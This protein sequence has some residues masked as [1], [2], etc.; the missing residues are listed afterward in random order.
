MQFNTW[1]SCD[2]SHTP[3]PVVGSSRISE[4]H[5]CLEDVQTDEEKLQDTLLSSESTF[6]PVQSDLE[7]PTLQSDSEDETETFEPDSL[8]PKRP[9]QTKNHT[10]GKKHCSPLMEKQERNVVEDDATSGAAGIV[11]SPGPRDSMQQ[12][13]LEKST[14]FYK[15][16]VKETTK[17]EAQAGT[18]VNKSVDMERAAV[19]IQSWWKGHYT[20]FGHPIARE[21]RS[22]IRQR[23]MQEHILFLYEKLDR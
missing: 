5:M 1:V 16:E 13:E 3:L 9:A 21:V 18:C 12:D 7:P 10:T 20:R 11:A 2:S 15:A 22:E 8:A 4:E 19:K 6:L 23:R 17:Q 14:D